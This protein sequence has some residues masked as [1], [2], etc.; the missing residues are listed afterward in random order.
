MGFLVPRDFCQKLPSFQN[1]QLT[2]TYI[3]NQNGSIRYHDGFHK[4]NRYIPQ[5]L[6]SVYFLDSERDLEKV[7]GN[8][9]SFTEDDLLNQMRM[10]CCLFDPMKKC[11]HCFSCIGLLNRKTPEE[12]NAFETEKL[13]EYKLYHMNLKDFSDKVNQYFGKTAVITGRSP[14][15]LLPTPE[16]FSRSRAISGRK[17]RK[18]LPL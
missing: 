14:M 3:A 18:T 6:P 15:I 12:L 5:I 13:L 7:Q 4:N 1:N 10:D 9:L 11:T 2:F 17:I 16:S 8:L